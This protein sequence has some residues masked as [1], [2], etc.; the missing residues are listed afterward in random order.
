MVRF[1]ETHEASQM[2]EGTKVQTIKAGAPAQRVEGVKGY[3]GNK[4]KH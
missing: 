1:H 3:E 4:G 2:G